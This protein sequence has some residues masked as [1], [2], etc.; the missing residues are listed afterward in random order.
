MNPPLMTRVMFNTPNRQKRN[1]R[2]N[3][4]KTIDDDKLLCIQCY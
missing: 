2:T 1:R 3:R 4:Q